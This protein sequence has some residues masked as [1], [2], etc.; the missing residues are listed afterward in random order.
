ML[1]AT[2]SALPWFGPGVLLA[3]LIAIPGCL[4]VGRLLGVRRPLAWAIIVCLGII[5]SATLT[6]LRGVLDPSAI[7]GAGCDLSRFTPPPM[8]VLL[9]LDD[10]SLNVALFIPLGI[11]IGLVPTAG[12]RTGLLIVSVAL[13]FAIEI[14]QL[15]VPLLDRGCQSGDVVDNLSGLFVG[16]VI[17]VGGR[18]LG[19]EIDRRE[20]PAT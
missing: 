13:P 15:I 2:I 4:V 6:P 10:S 9:H 12:P 8:W 18:V 3:M 16:L 7:A 11:A 5:L 20:G 19:S 1:G 14:T 17:G